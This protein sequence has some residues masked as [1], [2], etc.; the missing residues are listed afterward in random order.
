M[1][2]DGSTL[3][4]SPLSGTVATCPGAGARAP[5]RAG[6]GPARYRLRFPRRGSRVKGG[7]RPSAIADATP[8][9]PLRLEGRGNTMQATPPQGT[10]PQA[11]H[12]G[13]KRR[14]PNPYRILILSQLTMRKPREN[15]CT[16]ARQVVALFITAPPPPSTPSELGRRR[17]A[18]LIFSPSPLPPKKSHNGVGKL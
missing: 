7:R 12:D 8:G 4:T 10:R 18:P 2:G 1:S 3:R 5:C 17:F 13:A 9:A 6:P 14:R 11:A 16:T 15:A